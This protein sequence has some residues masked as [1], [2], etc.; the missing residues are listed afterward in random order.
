MAEFP[1]FSENLTQGQWSVQVCVEKAAGVEV[2]CMVATS[3]RPGLCTVPGNFSEPLHRC[4]EVE[5]RE[6]G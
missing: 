5:L 6:G 4:P 1:G 3:G 2:S